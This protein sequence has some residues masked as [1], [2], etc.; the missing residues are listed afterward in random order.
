MPKGCDR[1]ASNGIQ[2]TE[3]SIERNRSNR[4]LLPRRSS[5]SQ[6]EDRET[7]VATLL[8]LGVETRGSAT[9]EKWNF[10]SL[11]EHIRPTCE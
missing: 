2:K 8:D 11:I 7:G 3:R 4:E 5:K 1:T 6:L 10:H 9:N